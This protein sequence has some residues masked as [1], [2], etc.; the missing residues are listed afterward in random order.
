ME[1]LLEVAKSHTLPS[2]LAGQC[3]ASTKPDGTLVTQADQAAESAMRGW[4]RE[5]FPDDG[6]LGEEGPSEPGHS[7][8]TWVLDP[9]D[10]TA[11]FR[12]QVPLWGTLIGLRHHERPV[13]GACELPALR[14]GATGTCH[15]AHLLVEEAHRAC[16][17][18][19]HL[20]DS[21]KPPW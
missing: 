15:K 2:F 7:G 14:L 16:R 11:S 5:H 12:H 21:M 9:I 3:E 8:W 20:A 6:V 4:L 18:G 17:P 13:A 19:H 10:G 1:R